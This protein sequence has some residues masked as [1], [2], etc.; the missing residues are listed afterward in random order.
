MYSEELGAR[1]EETIRR[2]PQ[3]LGLRRRRREA[4]KWD[5]PEQWENAQLRSARRHF[6]EILLGDV[7]WM[8]FNGLEED[9]QRL[10][11][12]LNNQVAF[13]LCA[14]IHPTPCRGWAMGTLGFIWNIR[15]LYSVLYWYLL[16]HSTVEIFNINTRG[17]ENLSPLE[18]VYV[19]LKFSSRL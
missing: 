10:E 4:D 1:E 2:R 19:A 5:A 18:A 16:F 11:F 15:N 12:L 9:K 8:P 17:W 14:S 6:W 13:K 7:N 3:R